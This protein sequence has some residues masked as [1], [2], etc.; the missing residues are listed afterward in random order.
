[1]SIKINQL[2][3]EN[4]KRIK[5]CKIEPSQNGLTIIGG[6]NGQ[7]K[8]STLDAI[9]WA[10][11]GDRYRPS[12]AKRDGSV[13]PPSIHIEL[14]N[15]LIVE[16]RGKN[17]DLKVTDP[18]GKKSG[19]QLLNEFVEQLAIDLP[20]FM[21]SSNREKADTLLRIIGVGDELKRLEQEE[22]ELYNQRLAIG[23]IADQ[24]KKFAAEMQHYPDAP[25]DLIS[26]S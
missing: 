3:V 7:G 6:K 14:S 2:E 1:M 4:V 17:S 5:A 16:R 18:D 11:G 19:Q 8:T 26:L 21:Q 15:G 12:E 13:I 25:V 23:R 24:K 22:Q 20:R 9:A 10:L